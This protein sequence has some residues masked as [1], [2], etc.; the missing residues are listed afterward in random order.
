MEEYYKELSNKVE[1]SMLMDL[2]LCKFREILNKECDVFVCGEQYL[3]KRFDQINYKFC[4]KDEAREI[5][6]DNLYAILRFK[7]FPTLS[8]N[9]DKKINEIISSFCTNLKTTLIRVSFDKDS[10]SKKCKYLPDYCIA[11]RNGVY[12]FYNNNWFFK[13]T[14]T[15][16]KELQ[17]KIYS[18]DN[19]YIITWY[20]DIEFNDIGIDIKNTSLNEFIEILKTLDKEEKNYCFE[21]MYNMSFSSSNKFKYDKFLHLCEILGYTVL[22]SFSQNF[23]L[24]IGSGQNGKNSLFD[25]CFTHKII[26]HPI[27][28]DLDSIEEDRFITGSLE[29]K[30]HNIYLESSAK[31][32]TESK[33]LKAI[34]GSMYQTIEQKG[35]NKYSG[36]IN[37]KFIFA[38][39]DQDKIKFSDTTTGFRRR[40]NV[41]E[42]FYKWDKE[43][44]YLRNGDYYNVVFSDNLSELKENNINIITFIYLG[45]YGIINATKNFTKNFEFSYNDWKISY[46][47]IDFNLKERLEELTL[48]SICKYINSSRS[49]LESYKPLFYDTLKNRLY[50]NKDIRELGGSTFEMML[51]VLCDEEKMTRFF[52]ENDV[53]IN[54]KLLQNLVSDVSN[55]STFTSNVKKIYNIIS[56][57]SFYNN[58]P[59]LK[60]NFIN[61]K[62]RVVR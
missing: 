26:P 3:A 35:I 29:N 17:N 4:G 46:G 5:L 12:D 43:G 52:S 39:N 1:A 14:V 48:S 25:G 60:C 19:T 55:A 50:N 53:Y 21:L 2:E 30:A 51:D 62:M 47:D 20:V 9:V 31:T 28:N 45:M 33:M 22:Q 11:F 54:L 18:Y 40:I 10:D 6:Q 42:V 27:S 36:I 44:R 56:L 59:Y 38:G 8:D 23:V 24:F 57:P 41:Y 16:L 15:E 37:C 58:Q 13:Y 7:Y 32:Y 34:T 49:R 61:G